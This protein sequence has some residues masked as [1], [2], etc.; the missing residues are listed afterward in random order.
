MVNASQIGALGVC[1]SGGY[2]PFAAQTD[3][4]IRADGLQEELLEPGRQRTHEAEGASPNFT[5]I[6][7][8]TAADVS[9]DLPVF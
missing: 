3:D 5:R 6:F 7:P 4:R 1:V 2:V 8:Q 9:P